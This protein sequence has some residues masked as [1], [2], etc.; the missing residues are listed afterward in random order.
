MQ[1]AKGD[2]IAT[3][4][5]TVKETVANS[6]LRRFMRRLRKPLQCN[7]CDGLRDGWPTILHG[8]HTMSQQAFLPSVM[9]FGCCVELLPLIF[10]QEDEREILF[11]GTSPVSDGIVALGKFDALHIGHKELAI[12]ASSVGPPF[13][14]S[15]VGMAKVLGW[16]PSSPTSPT[17]P[18]RNSP[19]P[20]AFSN[21]R[22]FRSPGMM[23]LGH[24]CQATQPKP[25]PQPEEAISLLGR[26]ERP[27]IVF[28][29]GAVYAMAPTRWPP[30]IVA[31]LPTSRFTR[32]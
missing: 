22:D 29:K 25:S 17:S 18:T 16:E 6:K 7:I 27:L 5:V 10:Q 4:T 1:R 12:Q 14:L 3:V 26:A 21:H 28:G 2:E 23:C 8:Y 15:F 20:P 30:I 9:D 32:R 31:F 11:D 24:P 19:Q 13:L